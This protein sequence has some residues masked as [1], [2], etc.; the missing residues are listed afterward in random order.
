MLAAWWEVLTDLGVIPWVMLMVIAVVACSSV[1]TITKMWIK[2]RERMA[3]IAKGM[4]PG[5][6]KEAYDGD[7][8]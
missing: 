7:E 2:H 1:V 4:D 6:A 3:M 5:S 8:E